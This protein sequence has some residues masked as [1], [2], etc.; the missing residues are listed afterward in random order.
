VDALPSA[1]V[2]PGD[3]LQPESMA[4][5]PSGTAYIGSMTGGVLRVNIGSAHID[6]FIEPGAFGSGALYGVLAD[7]RHGLLWTCTNSF[8]A[9]ATHVAGADAGHWLKAFDLK[10]GA[11]RISLALPGDTPV[12]IV[13]AVDP[14]DNG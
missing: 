12:C 1:I 10:T 13:I 14:D 5:A 6:R 9:P 3:H 7:T 4:I 2:L 11:G 8:A